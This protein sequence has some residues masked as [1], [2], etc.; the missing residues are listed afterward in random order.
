MCALLSEAR[1]RL[2]GCNGGA[3]AGGANDQPS[4]RMVVAAVMT[5][6]EGIPPSQVGRALIPMLLQVAET[7][8]V[9]DVPAA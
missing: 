9:T 3:G 7:E 5:L 1:E 8:T 4:L 2:P 6:V